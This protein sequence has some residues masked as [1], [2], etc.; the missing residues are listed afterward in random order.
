MKGKWI[1]LHNPMAGYI[2]ARMRDTR[3]V[4]HSG[5]LEY[6]GEYSDNKAEC[7]RIADELNK[8]GEGQ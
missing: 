4:M 7:Q 1:V 5:N 3:Q 6:H 2:V 8:K